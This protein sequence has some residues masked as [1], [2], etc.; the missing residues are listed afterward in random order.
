M[1]HCK[2]IF[3]YTTIRVA[4]LSFLLQSVTTL[5]AENR[6]DFWC[7]LFGVRNSDEFSCESIIFVGC[8][9][10]FDASFTNLS[11]QLAPLNFQS[12]LLKIRLVKLLPLQANSDKNNPILS[13]KDSRGNIIQGAPQQV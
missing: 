1:S 2:C 6:N 13:R 7:R 3:Q 11:F 10:P 9:L 12:I 4:V 8:Q 5:L